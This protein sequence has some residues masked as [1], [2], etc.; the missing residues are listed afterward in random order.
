MQGQEV[1][2][3]LLTPGERGFA[4]LSRRS[5]FLSRFWPFVTLDII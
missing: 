5:A 4:Q 3:S 1:E 2:E